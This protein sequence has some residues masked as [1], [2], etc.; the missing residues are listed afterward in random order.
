MVGLALPRM[1]PSLTMGLPLQRVPRSAIEFRLDPSGGPPYLQL[2]QQ[3]EHSLQ[4]GYLQPGDQ[5]RKVR[6]VVASLAINPNTVLKSYR[7][8]ETKGLTTGLY[9]LSAESALSRKASQSARHRD[10]SP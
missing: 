9:R 3:V 2:V 5:L 1:T 10:R 4:L 8:L 7:E 6:D